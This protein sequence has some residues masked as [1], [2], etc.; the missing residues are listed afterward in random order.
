MKIR[1]RHSVH[2]TLLGEW[3]VMY[4]VCVFLLGEWA[5]MYDVCVFL[6]GEWAVMYDVCVFLLREWSVMYDVCVFVS[7]INFGSFYDLQIES[8]VI[9]TTPPPARGYSNSGRLSVHPSHFFVYAITWV[10]MDRFE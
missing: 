2:K 9:I 5:V 10:N 4:D 3:A 7:G 6:L 1:I 8:V